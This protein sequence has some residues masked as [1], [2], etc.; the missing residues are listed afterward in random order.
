[1]TAEYRQAT[2]SDLE[3]L[4][5]RSILENPGDP[6][7]IRWRD[8]FIRDN[9]SGAAATFAVILD[10]EPVGEGTLLFSPECR[11]VRGRTCLADGKTTA[12]INALRIREEFEGRGHISTL[13]K[14]MED[15][16]R[17]IGYSTVTIG[18]E[19]CEHRN[20]AIYSHWGYVNLI[21]EEAEDGEQV[22]YY[23]KN[24]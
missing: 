9:A 3:A 22:L 2:R 7:Y 8:Q 20:R 19:A 4:W 13:V 18:V 11:A 6:R 10:G 23:A 1:M 24:L 12:N 15:H 21:L 5:A 17:S 16:A 14:R